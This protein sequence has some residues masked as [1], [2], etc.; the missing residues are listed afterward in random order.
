MI[1]HHES[2][3]SEMQVLLLKSKVE[4]VAEDHKEL[5]GMQVHE[6]KRHGYYYIEK[7]EHKFKDFSA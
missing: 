2:G 7:V 3:F 6:I 5:W 1:Q 4:A